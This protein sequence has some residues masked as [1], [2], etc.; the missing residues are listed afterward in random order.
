MLRTRT[1]KLW[2]DGSQ[3][4]S[5]PASRSYLVKTSSVFVGVVSVSSAK[6]TFRNGHIMKKIYVFVSENGKK[7][8]V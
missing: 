2:L 8:V 5:S 3:L 1:S 4:S 7:Q 6:M